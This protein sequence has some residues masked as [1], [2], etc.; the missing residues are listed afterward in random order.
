MSYASFT[1]SFPNL[2]KGFSQTL[3]QPTGIAVMASVGIH[4][5]LGVSLP[6][7]PISSQ[8]KPSSR[9]VQLVQLSPTEQSRLPQLTPPP[10]SNQLGSLYPLPPGLSTH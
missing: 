2:L 3:F 4:A 6:Y 8:E 10:L 5:A 9:T 1:K 7:L